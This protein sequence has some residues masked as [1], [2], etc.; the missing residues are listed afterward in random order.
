VV[1]A[2]SGTDLKVEVAPILY[3]GDPKWRGYL[4]DRT[5]HKKILTSIPMHLDFIRSRKEKHPTHFAQ[6]IRLLKW[7]DKQREADDTGFKMRSF[8]V[9][10][11]VAKRAD[12]GC[13]FDDYHNA[14]EDFFVYVQNTGLNERIAFSDYYQQSALPKDR[15]GVVEMFD[16]VNPENN[17]AADFTEST[18]RQFVDMAAQ[19]LDTLAYA[20]TCQTKGDALECWQELMGGSFNA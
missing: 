12:D 4:F 9:E 13:K 1:I 16:P 5:T 7:W 11:I 15:A 2:F 10:L 3:D 17:V 6:V 8:L 20:R 18:R 19:A 14:I